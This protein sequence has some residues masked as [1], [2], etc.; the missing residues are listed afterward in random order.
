[1]LL[2]LLV[3]LRHLLMHLRWLMALKTLLLLLV[4]R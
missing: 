3:H 1:L 4:L 2:L